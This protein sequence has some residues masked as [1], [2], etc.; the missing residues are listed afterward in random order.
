MRHAFDTKLKVNRKQETS[1]FS[2]FTFTCL[3][4]NNMHVLVWEKKKKKVKFG[5]VTSGHPSDEYQQNKTG[6][7]LHIWVKD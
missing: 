6:T 3:P 1:D 4:P 5:F 7:Q 2:Y